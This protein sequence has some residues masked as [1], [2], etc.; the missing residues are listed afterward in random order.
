MGIPLLSGRLFEETD[1]GA[2]SRVVIVDASFAERIWPERDPVGQ[3]V[4]FYPVPGSEP[5]VPLW[6][7]VVGVVG[8]VKHH[9]LRTEGREQVYMPHAQ[10]RSIR[11][12]T[13]VVRVEGEPTGW[14]GTIRRTMT[15][16]DNGL[17]LYDVQTIQQTL[18]ASMSEPRLNLTLIGGFAVLA[19]LLAAVGTYG[20][21]AY[22]ATQRL[23]EIGIRMAL[24]ADRRDILRLMF[25]HGLRLTLTGIVIGTI[26]AFALTRVMSSQLFA[27]RAHDPLTYITIT[28]LL[29]GVAVAATFI[30]ARRA[31]K[32]DPLV[33][34]RCE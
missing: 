12:M 25:G 26:A 15:E 4:A 14:A 5:P 9:S 18:A 10:T 13:T 8:H 28:M 17:P 11:S 30:P 34:L 6:W 23:R 1:D 31:T 22:S 16:L 19:L 24:G 27:V 21:T 32:T 20:V 2:S 7:T 33:A 3:R 29:S